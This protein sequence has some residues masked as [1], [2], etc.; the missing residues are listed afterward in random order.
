MAE[1]LTSKETNPLPRGPD[2]RVTVC[3]VELCSRVIAASGTFGYGV[4]LEE[5]VRG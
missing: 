1:A 5:L 2:M 4:E 3:G